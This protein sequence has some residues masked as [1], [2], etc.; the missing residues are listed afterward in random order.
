[1]P[2][3]WNDPRFPDRVKIRVLSSQ[4][5]LTLDGRCFFSDRSRCNQTKR[6]NF[7]SFFNELNII[8]FTQI[9]G[10]L[11]LEYILFLNRLFLNNFFPSNSTCLTLLAA[12]SLNSRLCSQIPRH[13]NARGRSQCHPKSR[14]VRRLHERG[15]RFPSLFRRLEF[16]HINII[17]PITMMTTRKFVYYSHV[18][19]YILDQLIQ[20]TGIR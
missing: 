3:V 12:I 5:N 15:S 16:Y 18:L 11:W 7:I 1:M 14:R 9:S 4:I 8:S 2:W 19:S 6:Q 10:T 13:D 17:L 20:P